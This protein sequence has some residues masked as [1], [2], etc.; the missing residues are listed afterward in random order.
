M[1][2]VKTGSTNARDDLLFMMVD[3]ADSKTPKTGLT[4]TVTI[5]KPGGSFGSPSGTVSEIANGWYK[6]AANAT[7]NNT[8]G[9]LL[10]HATS[11]GAD[12]TDDRYL[13]GN[14]DINDAVRGGFSALPNAAAG[15]IGGLP[16]VDASNQVKASLTAI[17]GTALTETS[18]QIAAAFK[19]FFN[20]ATPAATMDHLVLVDTVT[21]YTGN[22]KQTGDAYARLGAPAGASN[23]ADIAALKTVADAVKAKSD[24]LTFGVT[25]TLNAN[26]TD[27]NGVAVVGN[28]S[29]TPWGP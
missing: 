2:P 14:Y 5:R 16:T 27:V 7:D 28:G 3:S 22:T 24:Q 10:L 25:N 12:P 29:G 6:V 20:I 8:I 18:G 21:T 26:I 15:A 1:Y 9:P 4:P 11:A 17:L 23:A 13:V 19:Q